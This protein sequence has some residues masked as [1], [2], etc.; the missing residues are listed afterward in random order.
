MVYRPYL[1]PGVQT[2]GLPPSPYFQDDDEQQS[3]TVRM[4]MARAHRNAG[5]GMGGAQADALADLDAARQGR[6]KP[7][8]SK[9]AGPAETADDHQGEDAGETTAGRPAG[10]SPYLVADNASWTKTA[11]EAAGSEGFSTTPE[12]RPPRS[13]QPIEKA[14]VP[15]IN[16]EASASPSRWDA[17][18][19]KD[20]EIAKAQKKLSGFGAGAL[21]MLAPG[22]IRMMTANLQGMRQ[23]RDD[24]A[25]EA[26]YFDDQKGAH[27]KFIEEQRTARANAR[28]A[29]QVE[30]QKQKNAQDERHQTSIKNTG[31]VDENG[32]FVYID[33]DTGA[34]R[35]PAPMPGKVSPLDVDNPEAPAPKPYL[36]TFAKPKEAGG[37]GTWHESTDDA[38]NVTAYNPVTGERKS[39]GKIGKTTVHPEH[40]SPDEKEAAEIEKEARTA[41]RQARAEWLKDKT[42]TIDKPQA[43]IDQGADEAYRKAYKIAGGTK[44]QKGETRKVRND[45][46][47]A[48]ETWTFDGKKFNPPPHVG[49]APSH[50]GRMALDVQKTMLTVP[51]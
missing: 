11:P 45:K 27:Q 38:G 30:A 43:A 50:S 24:L 29:A 13:S 17:V 22:V 26:A 42:N 3:P 8:V 33:P 35:E 34:W 36:P 12:N 1:G 2:P 14:D 19:A 9:Y 44:P 48:V 40:E 15:R 41:G 49:M 6:A 7:L 28:A 4:A 32:R 21:A 23:D 46:T 47:G 51:R 10:E 20:A 39:L 25:R 37:A 16:S 18:H 31:R 5:Y